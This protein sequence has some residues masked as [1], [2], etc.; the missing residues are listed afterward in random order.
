MNQTEVDAAV[1]LIKVSLDNRSGK[2]ITGAV[3]GELIRKLTPELD[4]RELYPTGKGGVTRFIE[5]YFA[6]FLTRTG[7]KGSDNLYSIRELDSEADPLINYDYWRSFVRPNSKS[8]IFLVGDPLK[9]N[10]SHQGDVPADA[11]LIRN[12]TPQELYQIRG[13]FVE[14]ESKGG[15]NPSLPPMDMPYP[16]WS[17]ALKSSNFT[18]YKA[19]TAFRIGQL[20]EVFADRLRCSNVPEE[21]RELLLDI[22]QRSQASL[23]STARVAPKKRATTIPESTAS[24]SHPAHHLHTEASTD[25]EFRHIVLQAVSNMSIAD[26]RDLKLPAGTLLDA[27]FSK[28][29]K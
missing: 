14:A 25:E 6:G 9:I 21:R 18:L 22:M 20:L 10:V 24:S 19:W 13:D 23:A 28:S 3:F 29:K 5:D 11:T 12:I 16:V 7:N 27:F 8:K 26:L 15:I 4:I 2:T 17:E 1:N